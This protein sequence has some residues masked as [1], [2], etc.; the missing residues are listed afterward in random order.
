MSTGE[1]LAFGEVLRR[2]RVANGLT[3]EALAERAGLS[4]RGVQDLERGV[5]HVPYVD[6]LRRLADA[7]GLAETDREVLQAAARRPANSQSAGAGSTVPAPPTGV[8]TF[9][10]TDVEG[11]TRLWQQD[12][13]RMGAALARHDELIEQLVREHHGTLVRPRG[14]GDSRFAVFGRASDAVAAACDIQV[15]LSQQVWNLSAPLRVR[16]AVHTGEADLR[17]G[18]YYA[19][20][21][22]HAA[23]LR[24]AA[25]GGQVLIS[26]V[27]ADL[28]RE[29][30][31]SDL[32]LQD[33][34]EHQ[35]KDLE[36]PEHIW[37]LVHPELQAD[38]PPL[39]VESPSNHNLQHQLSSFVGRDRAIDEVRHLLVSA[40]LVTLTGPGG[41]G[42]TRLALA[43][44]HSVLAD[45]TDGVWL[46]ELALLSDAALVPV[47]VAATLG[48]RESQRALVDQLTEVLRSKSMLL[49]LDNCEHVIGACAELCQRLLQAGQDLQILATSREPLGVI[50]ETIWRVPGLALPAVG[51]PN[52]SYGQP[53]TEAMQLF[54]ERAVAVAPEFCLSDHFAAVADVCRKLDGIPLAIELAAARITALTPEQIAERV[55][56]RFRLLGSGSRTAARRQ[57]TL[58]ATMDWSYDLLTDAERTLFNRLSVFA[59]GCTLEAAEVVCGDAEKHDQINGRDVLDLLARLVTCSLMVATSD[60][61]TA[62]YRMLET[63]RQYASE[64]LRE[65]DQRAILRKRHLYWCLTI[66]DP[67]HSVWSGVGG[68]EEVL[69]LARLDPEHDNI[70]LALACALENPSDPEPAL[71]LAANMSSFWWH[72]G[73]LAEGR[74]WLQRALDLDA[75]VG[76][77]IS[78]AMRQ[79]RQRALRGAGILAR[80]QSDYA[81]A[82]S[83]FSASLA[84]A[85]ELDDAESIADGLILLGFNALYR[86]DHTLARTLGEDSLA[87]YRQ[88]AD[89]ERAK[90]AQI[91]G[92]LPLLAAVAFENGDHAEARALVEERLRYARDASDPAGIASS[93]VSLGVLASQQGEHIRAKKL[94]E[95]SREGY[96]KIG[97]RT[98]MAWASRHAA[99]VARGRGDIAG[100]SELFRDS[101]TMYRDLG[102]LWGIAECL[103]GLAAVAA[104]TDQC[105]RAVQLCGSAA[106]LR[107]SGGFLCGPWNLA[108]QEGEL[109]ALRAALGPERFDVAW[110]LGQGLPLSEVINVAMTN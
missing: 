65:T 11:S 106:A 48:V 18:D 109:D 43:V 95:A 75:P 41:I 6:T 64:R 66:A 15:G 100:A 110:Q 87:W 62:R 1:R 36:R 23:R 34:G 14:E 104:D 40:R 25:H 32:G 76:T 12:R 81:T 17:L 70:R 39:S 88:F 16:M 50:G 94:L 58:R 108:R 38:Y 55:G 2:Y 31:A 30:L 56:D 89:P 57:Q 91:H 78:V 4:A 22:N 69:W 52:A 85:R 21:V 73:H 46:V 77:N 26:T 67:P 9:L 27:T 35:L 49:V 82:A 61:S 20:A 74:A 8:V 53:H 71:R 44:A 13:E 7:L 90:R 24:A 83:M 33:L 51:G 72:R 96:A 97:D 105:E 99:G 80:V 5:R 68:D 19:P 92:P 79:T 45:Y 93:F 54:A 98:G 37:Q 101:L 84:L 3:Q 60:G 28:V 42:K 59:S 102:A 103:E 63:L 29:A 86:G 10:F 107:E 47:T